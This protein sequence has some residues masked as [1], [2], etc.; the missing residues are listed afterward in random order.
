MI[1]EPE[2]SSIYFIKDEDSA[3]VGSSE[4]KSE[5]IKVQFKD[6]EID[7]IYYLKDVTQ[8]TTPMKDVEPASL[9]LSRYNWREAERPKTLVEFLDGTTL[10]HAPS[11]LY[12]PEA[13]PVES[14]IPDPEV[15]DDEIHK[16]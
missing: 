16:E 12:L 11:L 15:K 6:E 14:P 1:A 4:G 9:R 13:G 7:K 8:T 10:P 5:T 2:A 3:Y